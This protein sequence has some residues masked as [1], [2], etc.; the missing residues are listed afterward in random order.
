MMPYAEWQ[1]PGV[2]GEAAVGGGAE[3]TLPV[4]RH[5]SGRHHFLEL[6]LPD[7]RVE[8]FQSCKRCCRTCAMRSAF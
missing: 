6:P 4:P 7:G 1:A 3:Y 2:L 8:I 5:A